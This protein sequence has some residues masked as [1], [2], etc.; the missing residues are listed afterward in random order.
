M[1]R[2]LSQSQLKYEINLKDFAHGISEIGQIQE[3]SAGRQA[4][5]SDGEA[6]RQI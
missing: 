3:F 4:L 6:D 5:K 2:E 1:A